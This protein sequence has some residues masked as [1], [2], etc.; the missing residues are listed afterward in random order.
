MY[1]FCDLFGAIFL[2]EVLARQQDRIIDSGRQ[3]HLN[4]GACAGFEIE[5]QCIGIVARY[6][7]SFAFFHKGCQVG[8]DS[9]DPTDQATDEWI[10]YVR[11][12]NGDF[13][14]AQPACEIAD[15]EDKPYCLSVI[16]DKLG[17][18]A[19]AETMFA[20][21]QASSWG[22]AHPS[23][24]AEIYAQWGDTAHALDWLEAATRQ[25]DPYLAF[26]KTCRSTIPYVRSFASRRSSR[27]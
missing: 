23:L 13:R 21:L 1:G 4:H 17:R 27:S 26:L 8:D 9:T 11:C 15:E 14:G 10:G 19:D 22:A 3:G 24:G 20:K 12:R 25:Q 18:Y 5:Q 6:L 16:Y 2:Q 7:V